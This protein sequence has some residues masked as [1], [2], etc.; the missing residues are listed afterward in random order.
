[1][2][3]TPAQKRMLR[4]MSFADQIRGLRANIGRLENRREEMVG[5]DYCPP[6]ACCPS[7]FW[8]RELSDLDGAIERRVHYLRV[9]EC[10]QKGL[11]PQKTKIVMVGRDCQA[12]GGSG[13]TTRWSVGR[14][15]CGEPDC[16]GR[17][18]C[19]RCKG[20]G[21]IRDLPKTVVIRPWPEGT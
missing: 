3:L 14:C 4:N 5:P 12:C 15:T 13:R 9:L 18:I 20:K 17:G 1:V 7:C 16:P 19:H 10:R 8:G 6:N 21:V 2:K 11:R